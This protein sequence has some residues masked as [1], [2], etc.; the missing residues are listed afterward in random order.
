MRKERKGRKGRIEGRER[1]I[2][3]EEGKTERKKGE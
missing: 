3:R 1:E 2:K